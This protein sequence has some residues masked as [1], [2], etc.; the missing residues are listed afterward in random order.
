M[1]PRDVY[2]EVRLSQ[3]WQD[4]VVKCREAFSK[5]F[6]FL[7]WDGQGYQDG[8][9]VWCMCWSAYNQSDVTALEEQVELWWREILSFDGWLQV[10]VT[11]M[12]ELDFDDEEDEDD[13]D[14]EDGEE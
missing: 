6:P 11:N 10:R 12:A 13:E 7:Q 4:R 8:S 5:Q 3:G 9:T 14:W 1:D 2:V